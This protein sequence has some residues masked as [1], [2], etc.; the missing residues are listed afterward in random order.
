MSN[1]EE[2]ASHLE[3][4]VERLKAEVERL[5]MLCHEYYFNHL[6]AEAVKNDCEDLWL[7]GA[8]MDGELRERGV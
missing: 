8:A 7:E 6:H 3:D 2:Y 5:K 4:E 1:G